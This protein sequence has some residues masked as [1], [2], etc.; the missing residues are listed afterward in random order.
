MGLSVLEGRLL[1]GELDTRPARNVRFGDFEGLQDGGPESAV[2][3]ASKGR[4]MSIH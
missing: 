2:I 4:G 1:R 3:N